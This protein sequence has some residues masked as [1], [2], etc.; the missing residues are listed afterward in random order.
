MT[1]SDSVSEREAEA[2]TGDLTFI[3]AATEEALK[4]PLAL[5]VWNARAII[6]HA[7]DRALRAS[8]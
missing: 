6:E 5:I 8:A 4:D 7:K 3:R 2:A 1:L